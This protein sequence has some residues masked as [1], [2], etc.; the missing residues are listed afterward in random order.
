M[1]E[2]LKT[3]DGMGLYSTRTDCDSNGNS[4]TL[5][6]DGQIDY[7]LDENNEQV[8]DTNGNPIADAE[9]DATITSIG[10]IPIK[11][12][13]LLVT[14]TQTAPDVYTVDSDYATVFAAYKSGIPVDAVFRNSNTVW[15]PG[16]LCIVRDDYVEFQGITYPYD[17]DNTQAHRYTRWAYA[18]T[19]TMYRDGRLKVSYVEHQIIPE[20]D[21]DELQPQYAVWG[22]RRNQWVNA[23]AIESVT[24]E[25]VA[26]GATSVINNCFN[27]ITGT[28]PS[29]LHLD[30]TPISGE[31]VNFVAQ[32]TAGATDSTLV[33]T[34]NGDVPTLYN[35]DASNILEANKTYQ[36]SCLN[37]CWTMAAFSVPV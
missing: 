23:R 36:V 18:F 33:V 7:L 15:V 2:L 3:Y 29:V 34:T 16:K 1:A 21:A 22:R 35:K 27:V 30:C 37:N 13:S 31:L 10:N 5:G 12:K 24:V 14:L 32:V 6:I 20:P 26:D 17:I 28:I 19:A 9:S 25:A 8:L 11:S 4:L